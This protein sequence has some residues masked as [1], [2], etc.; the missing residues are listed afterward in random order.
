[1]TKEKKGFNLLV[2]GSVALDTVETHGG[3][4]SGALGGSAVYFS[5][6][7]SKFAKVALVGVVGKDFPQRNRRLLSAKNIDCSGL[8]TADG[9]T[10]RWSGV[11]DKTFADAVTRETKLNVFADFKPR[12]SSVQKKC[13]SVF[14]A[15]IDPEL[16]LSVLG[17][18]SE[19]RLSACDTMNYWINLKKTALLKLLRRVNVFFLNETEA[20]LLT[21]KHNLV[22][23]GKAALR[24][25][26]SAVVIKRGDSGV[27]L[28]SEGKCVSL[29]A[30]PVE[31]VV[32]TTGAGDS[33]AGGFMGRLS[34]SG[35]PLDFGELK[36]AAACG[37][38]TASFSIQSFSV[39]KLAEVSA[40][41]IK[42]RLALYAASVKI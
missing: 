34:E 12:L 17:Q 14:L 2:V 33:F 36:K 4:I 5:L 19:P 10:F 39:K 3:K 31:K 26:P 32:D 13:R 38:V 9:E 21:G 6:A 28:F 1:M 41:E 37:T 15:N 8:E 24:L 29:P 40:A 27:M 7:A 30:W 25:G 11:Y 20:R 23:A 22:A 42:N 18:L 16:Q 35:R